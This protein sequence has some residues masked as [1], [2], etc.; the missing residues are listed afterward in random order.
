MEPRGSKYQRLYMHDNE[1]RE[2]SDK[3][4][5]E[6]EREDIGY[7]PLPFVAPLRKESNHPIDMGK[8]I[9]SLNHLVYML[10]IG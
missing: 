3:F 10:K 7:V 2:S 8:G 9:K 5:G 6:D 4:E 1:E